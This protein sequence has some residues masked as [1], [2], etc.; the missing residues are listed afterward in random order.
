MKKH[1]SSLTLALCIALTLLPVSALAAES[2]PPS[3][4]AYAAEQTV[5]IDDQ[6]VRFQTYMLLE[7]GRA[8]CRERV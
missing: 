1:L 8:S 7:I 5:L 6:P 2:I 3:G 4:T